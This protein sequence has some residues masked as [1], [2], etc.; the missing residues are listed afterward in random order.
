MINGHEPSREHTRSNGKTAVENSSRHLWLVI[1][2][3]YKIIQPQ[4]NPFRAEQ[5]AYNITPILKFAIF[6]TQA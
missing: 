4:I 5:S 2:E 3:E 6:L 1:T